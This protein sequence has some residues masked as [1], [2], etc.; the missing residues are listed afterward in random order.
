MSWGRKKIAQQAL[1][2]YTHTSGWEREKRLEYFYFLSSVYCI[3]KPPSHSRSTLL[4]LSIGLFELFN[5]SWWPPK[6]SQFSAFCVP[7]DFV[8]KS[9]QFG[10]GGLDYQHFFCW[11]RM[12]LSHSADVV[13]RVQVVVLYLVTVTVGAPVGNN[14]RQRIWNMGVVV[15]ALGSDAGRISISILV[16]VSTDRK[17]E[18]W[19]EGTE[20]NKLPVEIR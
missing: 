12:I 4:S 19:N 16:I 10:A 8:V 18:V 2:I 20:G 15:H 6:M 7:I 17:N 11:H 5:S 14:E 3:E 9:S 1:N 13:R